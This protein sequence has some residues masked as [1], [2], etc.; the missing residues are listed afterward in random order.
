MRARLRD[1]FT[2]IVLAFALFC[3]V[4]ASWNVPC[5]DAWSNDEVSP[6]ASMLG[7][8]FE[9]WTPG[10]FF[11]YPP[12]HVLLLTV[13]QSPLILVGVARAGLDQAAIE[14][15]LIHTS[16]MTPAAILGRL[17][18][19][20]M[21]LTF[22]W[23]QKRL[24]ER[25]GSRRVGL[26]AAALTACNPIFVYF[27]HAA[28][29]DVPYLFWTSFALVELDRVTQGEPRERHVALF[30][31]AALLTKD[32]SAFLLFGPFLLAFG[33]RP[34]FAAAPGRRLLALWQPRLLRAGAVAVGIFVVASGM[35]TNPSGFRKKLAFM[36][37]GNVNWVIYE[38]SWHGL[39]EQLTDIARSV[40]LY[41]TWLVALAALGGLV[42]AAR[43]PSRQ[44]RLLPAVAAL[45]YFALFVIP[46]RWTMERH[47]MPLSLFL[48]PYAGFLL[49]RVRDARV[50]MATACAFL[51]PQ[52]RDIASIDGTLVADSRVEATRFLEGLPV[53]TK[54]EIYG[55]NQYLPLLPPQLD[56]TRV[57][58]EDFGARSSL[59]SVV[60]KKEPFGQIAT[61]APEYLVVSE[62]TVGFHAPAP[63]TRL[64]GQ[65]R[66]EA[67]DPDGQ[68]FFRGLEA[69]SGGYTRVL[70][71]QCT[72]PW[73]LECRRI[74][75]ST[76][77]ETWIYRRR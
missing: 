56:V 2:W 39:G 77:A 72:L 17:V 35:L 38:R 63:G 32:Q 18:A 36:K 57:G 65:G 7:A 59:P 44:R 5:T 40:P 11:R 52:I 33:F 53:G 26:A 50:A 48:L 49:E 6:R 76:G 55:G 14:R 75:L 23:N 20:A 30:A 42:V 73:P 28:S 66:L 62:S 9:T 22:V 12:L 34:M 46:S 29:V 45:S 19:F 4:G 37:S 43:G 68:A 27:A 16:Y 13:L 3:A 64:S 47:L 67:S 74:H 60:E 54:V 70:R 1:P 71:A 31:V 61:R 41:G 10:H 24:W 8:V 25:I 51:L 21:A 58:P 69:E 15:E